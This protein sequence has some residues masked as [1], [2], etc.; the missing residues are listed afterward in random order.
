MA[1]EVKADALSRG[2]TKLP[3][4]WYGTTGSSSGTPWTPRG[5]RGGITKP[6]S[7]SGTRRS[8]KSATQV[9][10]N[11]IHPQLTEETSQVT[12]TSHF[13]YNNSGTPIIKVMH[14]TEHRQ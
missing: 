3:H 1:D 4:S 13:P 2:I 12:K 6:S 5:P 8:R 9:S 14:N 10:Q 7:S 11:R